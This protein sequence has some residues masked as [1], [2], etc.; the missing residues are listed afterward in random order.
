MP[1]GSQVGLASQEPWMHPQ[2]AH[3]PGPLP[4][5]QQR[6]LP[7]TPD[8]GTTSHSALPSPRGD[9]G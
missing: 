3:L 6:P 8:S 4:P 7:A 5:R 9:L 1:P 2:P